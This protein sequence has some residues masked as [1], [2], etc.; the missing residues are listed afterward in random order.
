MESDRGREHKPLRFPTIREEI[1]ENYKAEK[2]PAGNKRGYRVEYSYV[3][4]YYA[5]NSDALKLRKAKIRI[6]ILCAA[7]L[8]FY[9]CAVLQK[10]YVN[11][12]RLVFG[13]SL[14]SAV[15]FLFEASGVLQFL[16]IKDMLTG[17][18]LTDLS[19]KLR[20]YPPVHGGLLLICSVC[21][22]AAALRGPGGAGAYLAAAGYGLSG[23]AS[24]LI[25]LL[26]RKMD[27]MRIPTSPF[28]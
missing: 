12:E 8:V 9:L 10:S 22:A 23:I 21:T 2:V 11:S 15:L 13:G 24:I 14:L 19:F 25:F 20:V 7:S 6:G 27:Y 3:G 18:Q 26:Y 5:Q 28:D 16:M 1:E 17:R 4:D